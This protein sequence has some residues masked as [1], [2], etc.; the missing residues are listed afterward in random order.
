MCILF[1]RLTEEFNTINFEESSAVNWIIQPQPLS[2]N[3][4]TNCGLSHLFGGYNVLTSTHSIKKLYSSLPLHYSARITF[5]LLKIDTW[6][7]GEAINI[8]IDG[9]LIKSI[10]L[11][12]LNNII[13]LK[14]TCG[15]QAQPDFLM[16]FSEVLQHV[17]NSLELE[18]FGASNGNTDE[19]WGISRLEIVLYKCHPSCKT[20]KNNNSCLTCE[21]NMIWLAIIANNWKGIKNNYIILFN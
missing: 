17:A 12:S 18:I 14:D 15:D 1:H 13:E 7:A 8:K 10:D 19:F 11:F 6:E 4:I 9:V 20:C 3:K 16:K 2:I 21:A 5:N